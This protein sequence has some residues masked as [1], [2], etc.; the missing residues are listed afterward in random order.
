MEF[1]EIAQKQERGKTKPPSRRDTTREN[2]LPAIAAFGGRA[3]QWRPSCPEHS[4]GLNNHKPW[5]GDMAPWAR[6]LAALAEDQGLSPS[7]HAGQFPP[8][9]SSTHSCSLWP[10]VRQTGGAVKCPF[11]LIFID[12]VKI[13][14]FS[15]IWEKFLMLLLSP[16]QCWDNYCLCMYFP[17]VLELKPRGDS[18]RA[19]TQPFILYIYISINK[20]WLNL[21]IDLI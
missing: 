17:P 11:W 3:P 15:S 18:H 20:N 13:L 9:G 14:N 12:L 1:E 21:F 2:H 6:S 7:T 19:T 8:R 5:A 16:L 10:F 4:S